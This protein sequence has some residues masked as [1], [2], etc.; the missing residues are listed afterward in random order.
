MPPARRAPT[1]R[2]TA[3]AQPATGPFTKYGPEFDVYYTDESSW[4]A[5]RESLA[6]FGPVYMRPTSLLVAALTEA[7]P[8]VAVDRIVTSYSFL[9][10]IFSGALLP[11]CTDA[12][13]ALPATTSFKLHCFA[14]LVRDLHAA[15]T[16]F[17]C[18]SG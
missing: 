1:A 17:I 13:L 18:H 15:D 16:Y 2:A 4:L 10:Y 12:V 11:H 14:R 6:G 8:A 5:A 3:P 9:D 7:L